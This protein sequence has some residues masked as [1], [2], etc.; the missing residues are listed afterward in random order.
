MRL[1]VSQAHN[2]VVAAMRGIGC[3][4]DEAAATADHLVDAGLR[5]MTFGSLARVLAISERLAADPGRRQKLAV[6][7]ETPV[8]AVIDGGDHV[9]YYVARE[10][11]SLAIEKARKLGIAVVGARNT[12]YTGLFSYYMEMITREGFVG[13][14]IGNGPAMVAPHGS[15]EA[16]LGTNPMAWGFPC[17][18]DPVIWDIGTCAIMHGE[19]LLHQRTGAKLPE[20]VALDADG[21]PTTDPAAALDGIVLPWGGYRGSGL[22]VVVQMLGALCGGPVI[23]PGM[24]DM[25]FLV[26]VIDPK[27]LMPDGNYAEHVAE[28]SNAIRGARATDPANPVRIPFDRSAAERRRRLAEDAIDVP[29]TVHAGLVRLAARANRAT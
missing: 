20:G 28:L 21:N 3:D 13:F 29:D 8:S 22:S 12:W 9:G 4:D 16:R 27:I 14:A 7:H 25:G 23:S 11:T 18:P 24:R 10:A 5:N 2:L 6:V 17:S 1:S 15:A 26:Q 19:L